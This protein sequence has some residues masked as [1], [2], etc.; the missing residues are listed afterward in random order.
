MEIVWKMQD[1]T[2]VR[3]RQIIKRASVDTVE[4]DK[5]RNFLNGEKLRVWLNLLLLISEK[6]V[7]YFFYH[8]FR[9]QIVIIS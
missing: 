5:I 3:L 1:Q 2:R 9:L 7:V 4:V 6:I 8:F